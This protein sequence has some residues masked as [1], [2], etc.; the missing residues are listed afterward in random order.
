[1]SN[2]IK[3]ADEI[4]KAIEDLSRND[5]GVERFKKAEE[6]DLIDVEVYGKD[7][8]HAKHGEGCYVLQIT[9]CD[10]DYCA[11]WFNTVGGDWI[12]IN[13]Y[14]FSE[15]RQLYKKYISN[16]SNDILGDDLVTN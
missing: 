9:I 16:T 5:D 13:H 7:F 15:W 10:K 8:R 11:V 14:E 3:K 6:D 1:M 2:Y 12:E 4:Y